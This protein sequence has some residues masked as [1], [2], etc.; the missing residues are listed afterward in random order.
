MKTSDL[1]MWICG[2]VMCYAA[3]VGV[4]AFKQHPIRLPAVSYG[5]EGDRLPKVQCDYLRAADATTKL[6]RP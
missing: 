1:A 3:V 4:L 6:C 5:S 2:V